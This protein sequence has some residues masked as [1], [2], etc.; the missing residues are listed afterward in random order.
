MTKSIVMIHGIGMGAWYWE[1]F[2]G[3]FEARGYRCHT[4]ILRHHDVDPREP[5]P[6]GLATTSLLDYAQDL[7]EYIQDLE[8]KPLLMGHSM[9]GLLAQML[10]ARGLASAIILLT[11]VP[12]SGINNTTWTTCNT[13]LNIYSKWGYWRKP[14]RLSFRAALYGGLHLI[15]EKDQKPTYERFVYDS[16]R[17]YFE[18]AMWYMD[19]RGAARVDAAKVT[20]PVLV[21][22][23][24]LDKVTL[25]Q[26]IRKIAAKYKSV[27]TY[28]EFENCAHWLLIEPGWEKVAEFVSS[29][30]GNGI[31]P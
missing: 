26:S 12:P 19:I 24:T 15:P 2:K 1:N 16:G 3:F 17:A 5:P 11:P 4:P 29:W 22:A 20:C 31:K 18:M 23:A 25:P 8:E 21:V 30:I 6:L 28:K 13:F 7:E 14:A 10:A 27:S 9:G